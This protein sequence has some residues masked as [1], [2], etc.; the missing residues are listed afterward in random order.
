MPA[1]GASLPEMPVDDESMDEPPRQS[2]GGEIEVR[3]RGRNLV[4]WVIA[5]G[6]LL[7]LVYLSPWRAYLGRL[8]E[9]SEYLKGL[10][11]L[12]PLVLTLAVALLVGAGFPRWPLCVIAGTALGFWSG[13]LWAQLGTLLGNYV[14]FLVVRLGSKEWAQRYLS[15]RARLQNV[16]QQEGISGV[17]LARQ[18]PLPGL[19]IN[20]A[21][22][23]LPLRQRDY[24]IGTIIGQMPL[25]IPCTLIGAGVLQ[26][27]SK[28]SV[29]LIGLAVAAAVLVWVGLR[30]A[31]R[32]Q[33]RSGAAQTLRAPRGP[34][35]PGNRPSPPTPAR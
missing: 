33:K 7:A 2:F 24:L 23:L 5:V 11:L 17:I 4:W 26:A 14:V 15:K 8:G 35:P 28:K 19:L 16:I 9:V 20:L 32:V 34:S 3:P 13:L 29:V 12:A 30:Y 18:M 1:I 25:A 22:G 10:G 27:S 21:C 6:A 31:L